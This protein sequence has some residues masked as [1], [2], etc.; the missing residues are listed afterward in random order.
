[1]N[2]RLLN[3]VEAAAAKE[4]SEKEVEKPAA[5]VNDNRALKGISAALLAKVRK[6]IGSLL[7]DFRLFTYKVP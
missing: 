6:M 7:N 2:P 3:S 5:P 4:K 1:M